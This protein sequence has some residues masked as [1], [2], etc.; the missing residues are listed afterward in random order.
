MPAPPPPPPPG[1]DL[2]AAEKEII[3]TQTLSSTHSLIE[4]NLGLVIGFLFDDSYLFASF[5]RAEIAFHRKAIGQCGET[6]TS[7]QVNTRTEIG[8]QC[9]AVQR[10]PFFGLSVMKVAL[11]KWA[12]CAAKRGHGRIENSAKHRVRLGN[13]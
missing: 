5:D 2:A 4:T 13:A 10:P 9:Q 1:C 11:T 6:S 7:R 3:A 12:I 8:N